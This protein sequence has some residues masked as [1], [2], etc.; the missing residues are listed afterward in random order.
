MQNTLAWKQLKAH[1]NQLD[2]TTLAELFKNDSQRFNNFSLNAAGLILDYS[3]NHVTQ[4]TMSLLFSLAEQRELKPS[5]NSMLRGDKI[6]S[7]ENR[8]ALHTALRSPST[9]EVNV[10]QH[11]IIPTIHQC[12]N[13]MFELSEQLHTGALKGYS[14]KTIKHFINIGIGGSYLGPKFVCEALLPIHTK[15]V[16][17]HF[18]ANIDA[19]E[20]NQTLKGLKLEECLFFIASK[21]FSTQETKLNAQTIRQRYIDNGASVNDLNK[22]FIAASTNIEAAVEFGIA[23][24][25]IFPLWDW[26]GGRYSLWSA[27]GLPI[28]IAIGKSN[29]QQLL[30]GA[31]QMDLHFKDAPIEQNLPIIMGLL[32]IWYQQFF[33]AESHCVLP[34]DHN[35]RSLT[36]HL[37]QLDMESLGKSIDA[38]GEVLKGPSGSIIW[39][40]EGTNGQHAFHQLLHQGTHLV[41]VDFIVAKHSPYQE[42]KHQQW[43]F[44][45]CL[46]Q[47][48]NLM[49][50]TGSDQT[51]PH[52]QVTGNKPSSTLILDTVKPST[53]GALIALYEH[54]VFVQASILGI[55]AFDQWGVELGKVIS[56]EIFNSIENTCEPTEIDLKGFDSSTAALI[57][58]FKNA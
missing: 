1:K 23:K 54:R 52:R 27:I 12:L 2:Q 31:H 35:L 16:D 18:I 36:N 22:H 53:L 47:S 46:A 6:N 24:D 21:S 39:G 15:E 8:S 40:G 20:L 29:F 26:V 38:S 19:S 45:N 7:S 51:D 58:L 17:V 42:G 37:Q 28:L 50:G 34:Y 32:A 11:N 56:E 48:R 49:I 5:I 57:N 55:N 10:N 14:G 9:E 4:E 30:S 44:A 3:K 43:L 13:K 33:G 41:P 25:N